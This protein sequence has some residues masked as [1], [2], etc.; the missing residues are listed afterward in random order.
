MKLSARTAV[1]SEASPEHATLAEARARVPGALDLT[2]SNPTEVGLVHSAE[3]YAK[4]GDPA[5][6]RYDPVPFGLASA[7]AAV[8]DH[9]ARREVAVAHDRVWLTASTSEAY[10]QLMLLACDPG[11]V[12]WVPRPGYPLLDALA[13]PFGVEL[14]GYPMHWHGR[15]Q[16]GLAELSAAVAAEP[17]S[18]AIVAVAPGNPTGAYL[19]RAELDELAQLCARRELA[20][21]VDEVFADHE[22]A[23]PPDRVRHTGGALPCATFVL[24]G[25]SKVAAL[26]QMKLGWVV[27]HG[28]EDIVAPVLARAEH[29]ADAFLSVATPVQLA[30]PELLAAGD[31][32]R[33]RVRER[34]RTNLACL[35]AASSGTPMDVLDVEGGWVALVRLPSVTDDLGWAVDLVTHA[36]VLV[37]PGYLYD[38]PAPPRLAVSLLVEP[39][40]FAPAAAAI[41]ERVC[42][43][44]AE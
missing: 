30:L 38:L 5:A 32:L 7:R 22:V 21:V 13:Q 18:R 19:S 39:D 2:V 34:V 43:R 26:P 29:L 28:P 14:R 20:L 40:R 16:V 33:P 8:V 37:Q 27:A 12:W 11:D 44:S 42:V 10:A 35:R 4:L 9:Y 3:V 31:A 15:W 41:A 6:A 24:S 1:P 17:R 36:R 25:L 23:V